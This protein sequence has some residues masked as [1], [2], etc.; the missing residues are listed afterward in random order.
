VR[1]ETALSLPVDRLGPVVWTRQA[2]FSVDCQSFDQYEEYR[3]ARITSSE[4]KA[5]SIDTSEARYG[6]RWWSI[7][8]LDA[9]GETVRPKNMAALLA[10]LLTWWPATAATRSGV[11]Q[12]GHGSGVAKEVQI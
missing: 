10:D 5:I 8:E 7:E 6:H 1:E 3:L 11:V 2:I 4:A 12:R 9:T